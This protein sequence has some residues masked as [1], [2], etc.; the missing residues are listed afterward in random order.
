MSS[1]MNDLKLAARDHILRNTIFP[2]ADSQ[3]EKQA[4]AV[5]KQEQPEKEKADHLASL[6]VEQPPPPSSPP[7]R[8]KKFSGKP[9]S[10]PRVG[11]VAASRAKQTSHHEEKS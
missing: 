4:E 3:R 1:S 5:L 7:S 6:Q 8:M 2:D 11:R 10:K 9:K